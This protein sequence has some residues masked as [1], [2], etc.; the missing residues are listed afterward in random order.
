[1]KNYERDYGCIDESE[2]KMNRLIKISLETLN[3]EIHAIVQNNRVNNLKMFVSADK[4]SKLSVTLE[5]DHDTQEMYHGLHPNFNDRLI[6]NFLNRLK[7]NSSSE[8][9]IN[10][11]K[12]QNEDIKLFHLILTD[13]M[14]TNAYLSSI[15]DD[16]ERKDDLEISLLGKAIL[17]NVSHYGYQFKCIDKGTFLSFKQTLIE[18]SLEQ[19]L[20]WDCSDKEQLIK[21]YGLWPDN[22]INNLSSI[23]DAKLF[24]NFLYIEKSASTQMDTNMLKC[25]LTFKGDWE[26]HFKLLTSEVYYSGVLPCVRKIEYEINPLLQGRIKYLIFHVIRTTFATV[27]TF[28]NAHIMGHPFF[29]TELSQIYLD[30]IIEFDRAEDALQETYLYREEVELTND[31][32]FEYYK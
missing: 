12:I 2:K 21:L 13:N 7:N 19:S 5:P 4:K 23:Y 1:L 14:R 8:F 18:S 16:L 9:W 29:Q 30:H 15:K 24:N 27:D 25:L 6:R 10:V 31:T 17:H 28:D 20:F 3:K 26:T 22:Q 32:Q 11:R